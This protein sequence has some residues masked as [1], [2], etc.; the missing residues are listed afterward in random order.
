M[1][2]TEQATPTIPHVPDDDR[3]A[4]TRL[5]WHVLA[6]HVLAEE[7]WRRAGRIGLSPRGD[8]LRTPPDE[9][10]GIDLIGSRLLLRR[11]GRT[12]EAPVTTLRDAR[13]VILGTDDDR[14]RWAEELEVHD[15]P[16]Q[17]P[18]DSIL[19]I[20]PDVAF[21][22]GE[23]FRLGGDVLERLTADEASVDASE[24]TLWPEHLDIAIEALREDQR[25][26]YGLSPGDDGVPEP[27][28]YVAVWYPDRVGGLDDP[29]WNGGSFPGA[30]LTARELAGSDVPDAH[31]LHW[32]RERR[33]LLAASAG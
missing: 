32:F 20:D 29:L 3:L 7:R 16:P 24:P 1:H 27:Y 13:R 12:Y 17:V 23:W 15:P 28:A 5:S 11:D 26:S 9:P 33:D 14:T 25:A 18:A 6:G 10:D 30:R 4:T 8:G 22:L 2:D 19:P 31:L 21:W